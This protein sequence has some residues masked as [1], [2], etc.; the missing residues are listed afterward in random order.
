MELEKFIKL[1]NPIKAKFSKMYKW[2]FGIYAIGLHD[3]GFYIGNRDE[4]I[5]LAFT[6]AMKP[7]EIERII[8]K[9]MAI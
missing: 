3:F 4:N 1:T 6:S 9:I 2:D 7:V 8:K 5:K